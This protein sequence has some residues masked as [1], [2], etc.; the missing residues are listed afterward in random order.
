MTQQG[1]VPPTGHIASRP[2]ADAARAARCSVASAPAI[3]RP[4]FGARADAVA[5]F[6]GEFPF[7][8]GLQQHAPISGSEF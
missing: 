4:S 8:Q 6:G 3:R 1:P 2:H 7:L 5:E